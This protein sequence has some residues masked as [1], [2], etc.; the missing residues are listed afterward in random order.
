ML[1]NHLSCIVFT[2]A[3]NHL[4]GNTFLKKETQSVCLVQQEI[5]GLIN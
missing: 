5:Y 2:Q 4:L 1:N 3:D